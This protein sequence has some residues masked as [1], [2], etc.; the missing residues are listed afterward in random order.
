MRPAQILD[1]LRAGRAPSPDQIRDVVRGACSGDWSEAQIGAFLMAVAIRDLE[2]E[3]S[4]AL[5]EAMLDSGERWSLGEQFPLLVDKHSTGGVGD[6]TSLVLAPL[7]AACGVPVVMLTG[8]A[9]GHT[10]GTADKLEM[11]PGLRL[12]VNR[13]RCAELISDH[14]L[15]IGVATEGIAPADRIFYRLRDLTGTVPSLALVTASILSKKLATGANAIAF[16]VKS[17]D[18]AI[19]P[20][21]DI[22]REL[23]RRMVQVC[24][25][26]GCASSALL[27]DM[28]QPLGR[29]AGGAC[30]VN[31]SVELLRGGGEP[32]LRE[33]CLRLSVEAAEQVG[34]GVD[35]AQLEQALDDGS[36]YRKFLQWAAAQ[37]AE[38]RWLDDPQLPLADVEYTVRAPRSGVLRGV[39]TR[40]IGWLLAEVA[41]SA[42]GEIDPGVSVRLAAQLGDE[43]EE[44]D[45]LAR[46]FWRRSESRH[47]AT[48]RNCF[49]V[50]EAVDAPP[51]VLERIA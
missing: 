41:T 35:R 36:A 6:K 42:H 29:W 10:G 2:Q 16:D 28:S 19:F 43:V 37:G 33:L 34:A 21:P 17:G 38:K 44:G 12:A 45:E 11:V 9:L 13:E 30:E 46:F 40:Q 48:A 4:S 22:G 26:L 23:A 5:T 27:T 14:G 49:A 15:A 32:R 24:R 8:R 31:E 18:G 3:A 47:E 39:E 7:L 25:S 51:I 50:G 20:D 1:Q